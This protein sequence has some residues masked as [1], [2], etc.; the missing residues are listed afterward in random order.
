VFDVIAI[1]PRD[2]RCIQVKVN[3][4]LSALEREQMLGPR[5]PPNVTR[6]YRRF[7]DGQPRT[8]RIEVL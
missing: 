5:L 2:V 1:G 3:E 8:P 4:Y 6:Q 7:V